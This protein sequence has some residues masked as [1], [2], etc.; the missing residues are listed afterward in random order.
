MARESFENKKI[1][2]LLNEYFISIKVDREEMPQIDALYQNIFTHVHHRTGGWPLSVFMTPK[3]E[4]F[5]ITGYILTKR[6][7]SEGF[8]DL[9]HK[10][11]KLFKDEKA[12]KK[13]IHKIQKIVL[14]KG[15]IFSF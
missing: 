13:E 14:N 10:L 9:I 6:V 4:V 12:L 3:R 7:L 1:A 8:P 5:Y 11:S 2:K 15:K